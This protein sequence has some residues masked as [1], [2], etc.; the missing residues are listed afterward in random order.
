M[1]CVGGRPAGRPGNDIIVRDIY[2][3]SANDDTAI[4][5]WVA[6]VVSKDSIGSGR[7]RTWRSDPL[8][9]DQE[10][11]EPADYTGANAALK[12]D[13]G[14]QA[15]LASFGAIESIDP[16]T[17]LAMWQTTN[18]LSNIT[19]QKSNMN[20]QPWKN[21]EEAVRT[22]AKRADLIFVPSRSA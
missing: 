15:P 17:G 8:L 12:T 22:V 5:D 4:A 11:L 1:H 18:L 19:A 6:Y 21:L 7:S 9:E 20:Q 3:F 14:H 16:S 10:T 13:R 2:T